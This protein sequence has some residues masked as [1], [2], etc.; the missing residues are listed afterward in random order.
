MT[1]RDLTPGEYRAAALGLASS[2]AG[3]NPS[4]VSR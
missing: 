4:A 2:V 1:Y 3:G